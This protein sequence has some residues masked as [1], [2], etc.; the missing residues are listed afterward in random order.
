MYGTVATTASVAKGS[1]IT[2]KNVENWCNDDLTLPS[3]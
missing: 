1:S 2:W 3:H